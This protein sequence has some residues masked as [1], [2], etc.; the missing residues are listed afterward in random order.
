[1]KTDLSS[2]LPGE[3]LDKD[4]VPVSTLAQ[5]N[6]IRTTKGKFFIKH[7][8]GQTGQENLKCEAEGLNWLS[9]CAGVNIPE[10]LRYEQLDDGA[11]LIMNHISDS[12][13]KSDEQM[14]KMLASLHQHTESA[15]GWERDN[16]IGRL[17]QANEFCVSWPEFWL[18]RRLLPQMRMAEEQG[19]MPSELH[20]DLETVCAKLENIVPNSTPR[21]LHGDLWNGNVLYG[22]NGKPYFIDP[23]V[24]A[25][26]REV[27][28]AM[29]HLFGGFSNRVMEVYESNLPLPADW[30]RRQPIY[31]LYYALVHVNMFGRSY[32]GMTERLIHHYL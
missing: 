5:S 13:L 17:P 30:P 27:D 32:L 24:F 3:L 26:D 6:I 12:H 4:G 20:Q 19:L 29:M 9:E 31:Q 7:L 18:E 25:G 8:K 11:I 23:A 16:F 21:R 14:G 28:I 2:L 1:M 15:H 10:N 22:E